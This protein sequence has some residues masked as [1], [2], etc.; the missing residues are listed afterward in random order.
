MAKILFLNWKDNWSPDA[1]G[2]ELVLSEII[3][4]AVRDGHDPT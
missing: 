4:R 2:A 3:N 1:G